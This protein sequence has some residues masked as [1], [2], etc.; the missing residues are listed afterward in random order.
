MFVN[1]QFYPHYHGKASFVLS[2][3][4]TEMNGERITDP[5]LVNKLLSYKNLVWNINHTSHLVEVIACLASSSTATLQWLVS[6]Q[7]H[8]AKQLLSLA[9][10]SQL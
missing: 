3:V 10:A 8:L 5:Q 1:L 6:T 2:F 4:T 9:S 7:T